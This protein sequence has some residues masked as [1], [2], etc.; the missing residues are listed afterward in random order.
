MISL[1]ISFQIVDNARNH[2]EIFVPLRQA[3]R[4]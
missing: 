3:K 2:F 4:G 1:G